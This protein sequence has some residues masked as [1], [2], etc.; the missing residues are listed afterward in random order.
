MTTKAHTIHAAK[1]QLSRLVARAERGEEVIIANGRRPVAKLVAVDAP[2][3]K[4][5]FGSMKGRA[6]TTAAF[7]E[8][9]SAGELER[10][11]Q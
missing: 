10:W 5:E 2:E 3:P 6:G 11:E 1:T 9:L 4:R 8:S 7:F